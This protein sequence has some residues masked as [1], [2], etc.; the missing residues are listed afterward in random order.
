MASKRVFKKRIRVIYSTAALLLILA[1]A[2][3]IR[4][5]T[6]TESNMRH[7]LI[8]TTQLLAVAL[9]A[10][11]AVALSFNDKDP[12]RP[13]FRRIRQQLIAYNKQAGYT[14]ICLHALRDGQAVC[15]LSTLPDNH[16]LQQPY[17]S[18]CSRQ[19]EKDLHALRDGKP[20]FQGPVES[21]FGTVIKSTV[22]VFHP[23]TGEVLMSLSVYRDA[24]EWQRQIRRAQ[25]IPLLAACAP[26]LV[27]L[28]GWRIMKKRRQTGGPSRGRSEVALCAA[29][30]LLLTAGITGL[31]HH[32]ETGNRNNAFLA[33]AQRQALT[34]RNNFR[35]QENDLTLLGGLFKVTERVSRENFGLFSMR[36]LNDTA[37]QNTGWIQQIPADQKEAFEKNAAKW[38][39]QSDY[40]IWGHPQK[41]DAETPALYY[42]LLY[43]KPRV[44]PLLGFDFSSEPIRRE[45]IRDAFQTRLVTASNLLPPVADSPATILLLNCTQTPSGWGL[46]FLTIYPHQLIETTTGAMDGRPLVN[47][48]LFELSSD[49]APKYITDSAHDSASPPPAASDS[50]LTIP[51]FAFGKCYAAAFSPTRQWLATNP[52]SSTWLSVAVGLI[53]SAMLIGLVSILVARPQ[54]L[55]A[56]VAKRTAELRKSE[57]RTQL[58][59]TAGGIGI[60]DRDLLQNR[61]VWDE[62]MYELYGVH[63]ENFG[64]A[65]DAWMQCV[66]PE[67]LERV[68]AEVAAAEHDATPLS[69][70]FRIVRPDGEIR[71]IRAVAEVFRDETGAPVRMIGT[72][73]DITANKQAEQE[74]KESEERLRG[75]I[76]NSTNMFY[77][78]TPDH[79]LTYVSPQ[80][81]EILGYE[82]KEALKCWTEL[83][84]DHPA[85]KRGLQ[86]TQEAIRTGKAQPTYELQLIHKDGHLVWVEVREAPV[87]ENEETVAITGSLTDITERKEAETA[88]QEHVSE[89][90]RF[91]RAAVGREMRMI[92][93]KKEINSLCRKLGTEDAYPLHSHPPEGPNA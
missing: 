20:S 58:A 59:T 75:I 18:V 8:R 35:T 37:I 21:P 53:L 79:V 62:R 66:H 17:G 64:G 27:L 52:L 71:H 85:N 88:L 74:L 69:T 4:N 61:L 56:E 43:M 12:A 48:A 40:R 90:H 70:E 93:L 15:G 13:Q 46:A 55:E 82:A 86:L 63:K 83:A 3:A 1:I 11:E 32:I 78:H 25:W 38:T 36:L 6:R 51:I 14:A 57:E 65:H 39:N 67:D 28:A 30:S 16:P 22:P 68:T 89:L 5:G 26:L 34:L 81:K 49:S 23:R 92:E 47:L 10:E 50:R 60:W 72:N 19:T 84:S 54:Q 73:Q 42:P 9:P 45:A 91:N 24:T 80:I 76:E 41:A 2:G 33:L 29:V 31:V 44:A 87:V 7:E 77:S